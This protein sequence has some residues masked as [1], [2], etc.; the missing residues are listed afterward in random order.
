VVLAEEAHRRLLNVFLGP[1]AWERIASDLAAQAE[2]R[3]GTWTLVSLV[4]GAAALVASLT[5]RYA[6]RPDAERGPETP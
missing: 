2:A 4:L 1:E 3:L 5:A 6:A